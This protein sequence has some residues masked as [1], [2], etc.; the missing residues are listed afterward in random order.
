[1]KTRFDF[2]T[3]SSSSSFILGFQNRE[4]AIKT[5]T[6][7]MSAKLR[8]YSLLLS[9]VIN[10]EPV[11]KEALF[12]RLTERVDWSIRYDILYDDDIW[13]WLDATGC[14]TRSE[15]EE[16]EKYKEL[17]ETEKDWKLKTYDQIMKTPFVIEVE[18]G[19]DC[20]ADDWEAS[21]ELERIL[22]KE[23]YTMEAISHH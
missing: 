5:I 20:C 18:H 16:T 21:V 12:R 17:F 15:F 10:A 13:A 14:K 11:D 2:V 22:P 3:N 8:A 9:E 19:N 7:E 6:D 1:M 23:H 4:E